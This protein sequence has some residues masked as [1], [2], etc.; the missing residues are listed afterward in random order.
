[1]K[2]YILAILLP[3]LAFAAMGCSG[4]DDVMDTKL[5]KGK[6]GLITD[7]KTESS[8]VYDFSTQSEQTWSWGILTTYLLTPQ[9]DRMNETI[10]DWHISD[11]NNDIPVLL[12]ITL[13]G[14]SSNSDIWEDNDRFIVEQLT[15]TEMTL[16]KY[17]VG[18][19]KTQFRFTR[20]S[21]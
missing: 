19:S 18:D 7:G 15:A 12:D 13:K 11:P 17:E 2:H 3:L 4:D 21:N 1:M 5:L 20:L 14:K 9:G 10:Y 16:R 6:W 8:N